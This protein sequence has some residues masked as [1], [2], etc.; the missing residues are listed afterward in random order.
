M[1]HDVRNKSRNTYFLS[2]LLGT[3]FWYFGLRFPVKN[4]SK[5]YWM[6]NNNKPS[7]APRRQYKF[8]REIQK[9]ILKNKTVG[10]SSTCQMDSQVTC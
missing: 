1:S 8:A 3:T 10:F 2:S 9:I 5:S 4:S 6:Q 7:P